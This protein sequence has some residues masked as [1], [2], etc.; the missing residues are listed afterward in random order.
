MQRGRHF[1]ALVGVAPFALGLT[2][3]VAS[4]VERGSGATV[5]P[6]DEREDRERNDRAVAF[7]YLALAADNY[8]EDPEMAYPQLR[9]AY[10]DAIDVGLDEA[11]IVEA[12]RLPIATLKEPLPL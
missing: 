3:R 4:R 10:L 12:A 6:V 1:G 2:P 5:T 7:K 11:T 8:R 9:G